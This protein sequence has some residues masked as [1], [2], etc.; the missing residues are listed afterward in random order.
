MI[1]KTKAFQII[2]LLSLS[3]LDCY[4]GKS[5]GPVTAKGKDNVINN[6]SKAYY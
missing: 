4:L 6:S 1:N 3:P 5:A 2:L